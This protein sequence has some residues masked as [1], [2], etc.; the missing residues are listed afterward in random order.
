M[1]M[2]ITRIIL[3]LL[4]YEYVQICL[5]ITYSIFTSTNLNHQTHDSGKI[6]VLSNERR[7]KRNFVKNLDP[8]GMHMK[9][10]TYENQ[11]LTMDLVVYLKGELGNHL[12]QIAMGKIM[13]LVA[14][15]D[16][17]FHVNTRYLSKSEK[18]SEEIHNCFSKNLSEE[19]MNLVKWNVSSA[20]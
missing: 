15:E 1:S 11:L 16:G 6:K 19:K 9:N 10:N 12:L 2:W 17:R 7:P 20:E 4:A 18:T 5:F 3:V 8:I 14:L 13:E